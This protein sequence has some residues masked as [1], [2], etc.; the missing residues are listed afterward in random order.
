ATVEKNLFEGALLVV[1][2]LFA[3]L[4][5]FRAALITAAVIPLSMLFALTGMAANRVSGNLMSLGAIDFGLI[6]DGAVIVVENC[7]TGLAAA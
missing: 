4:G 6:V 1:V 7:L 2:V 3:L 5:N